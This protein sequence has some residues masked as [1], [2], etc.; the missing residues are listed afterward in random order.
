MV[1]ADEGAPAAK[2]SGLLGSFVRSM[3]TSIT[4]KAALSS[5]DIQPALAQLKRKLMERNVAEEIA[6]K[7]VSSMSG[8]RV[9]RLARVGKACDSS[10]CSHR[11]L[12]QQVSMQ[13][14][15]MERNVAERIAAMRVLVQGWSRDVMMHTAR[16]RS[17]SLPAWVPQQ[18]VTLPRTSRSTG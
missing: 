1:S 14:K 16:M 17:G 18:R 12:Q 7:Y 5:E 15:L 13:R 4:G 2:A 11:V 3:G 10:T 6:A 9:K 8:A